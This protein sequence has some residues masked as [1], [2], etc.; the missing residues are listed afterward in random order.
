MSV[1]ERKQICLGC[2]MYKYREVMNIIQ[3]YCDACGC[4]LEFRLSDV[5]FVC[6]LGKFR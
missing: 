4:T 6:P 2:T 1:E 5:N 3:Q